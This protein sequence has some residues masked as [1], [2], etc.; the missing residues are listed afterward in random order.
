MAR[1]RYQ[2][3]DGKGLDKLKSIKGPYA[4]IWQY[5]FYAIV[6]RLIL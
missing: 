6:L 3:Y 5:T 2:E 1:V 4:S